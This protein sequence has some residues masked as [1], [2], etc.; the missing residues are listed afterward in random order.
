MTPRE[1]LPDRRQRTAIN[2]EHEGH[3]FTGGAGHY[4]DGRV[5]EVFISAGKTGTHLQ[6][7]TADA[8]I[9]ASIALQYGAPIDVLRHAFLRTDEGEAAGPLGHLFDILG[10]PQ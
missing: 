2:F 8:A 9:A 10:G 1:T 5:G 7:A 6:I 3:A 4:P